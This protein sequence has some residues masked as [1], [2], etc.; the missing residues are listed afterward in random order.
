MSWLIHVATSE[1]VLTVALNIKKLEADLNFLR[2]AFSVAHTS[3]CPLMVLTQLWSNLS[4]ALGQPLI[5]FQVDFGS[6]S[7]YCLY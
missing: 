7:C 6:N 5:A 4:V 1:M 2:S 3:I